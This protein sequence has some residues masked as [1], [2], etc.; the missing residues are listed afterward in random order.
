MGASAPR[1]PELN[2]LIPNFL[3]SPLHIT[4]DGINY[5]KGSGNAHNENAITV[6]HNRDDWFN[7]D[8]TLDFFCDAAKCELTIE[9]DSEV[10]TDLYHHG[11][12]QLTFD[13]ALQKWGMKAYRFE[14][15][16]D[17]RTEW[18]FCSPKEVLG[19]VHSI[20]TFLAA[21]D[22]KA[23][24]STDQSLMNGVLNVNAL[25]VSLSTSLHAHTQDAVAS[26]SQ[27]T[28]RDDCSAVPYSE[29]ATYE[30]FS[31]TPD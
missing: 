6:L 24:T 16:G 10:V 18:K 25:L 13:R 26:V 9:M 22:E 3:R 30:G 27:Y 2:E 8:T 20:L 7:D 31:A 17:E 11:L 21:D 19:H 12:L 29:Q 14:G 1:M 23:V 28:G 15:W 4:S 5:E